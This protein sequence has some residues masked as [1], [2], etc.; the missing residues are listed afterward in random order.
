[1]TETPGLICEAP[2][3]EVL[4][5]QCL[6]AAANSETGYVP[7]RTLSALNGIG[8]ALLAARDQ[9]AAAGAAPA[10][11][12]RTLR[13]WL[14]RRQP[15]QDS[16]DDGAESCG[17]CLTARSALRSIGTPEEITA[18]IKCPACRNLPAASPDSMPDEDVLG[19]L[20]RLWLSCGW[21]RLE[22]QRADE[23]G[24]AGYCVGI[25]GDQIETAG[26]LADPAGYP[27]IGELAGLLAE[28]GW[29]RLQVTG[30]ILPYG[31]CARGDGS[32]VSVSEVLTGA[33]FDPRTVAVPRYAAPQVAAVPVTGVI[34]PEP[35]GDR[36]VGHYQ[37]VLLNTRT[38]ELRFHENTAHREPWNPDWTCSGDVPPETRD[39]W[40]PG[41]AFMPG[42][43]QD[44]WEPVPELLSWTVDSGVKEFPYLDADGANAL[45]DEIAPFA[46]GLLDGLYQTGE[47]LD[48]SA[49]SVNIGRDIC[50]LCSRKRQTAGVSPG[51]ADYSEIVRRFPY[52]F[53]PELLALP[54]GRLAGECESISRFLGCNE[55]WNPEVHEV[56]AIARYPGDGYPELH[57]YG[58][59]SWYRAAAGLRG[60]RS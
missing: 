48:W 12:K 8:Y 28:S 29:Q 11:G 18:G 3:S 53:R 54:A 47:D 22:I 50:G 33:P 17:D 45:L 49:G 25:T 7:E 37:Q 19:R 57:V 16:P 31:W 42:G 23:D 15:R 36:I 4:A 6:R 43:G 20:N 51:N 52:L 30:D 32:I 58:V 14:G 46:Q 44:Q 26:A 10:K 1:M 24:Y 59:R 9:L 5:L 40:Y 41:K 39:R 34:S 27:H 60:A 13:D 56:F 35:V 38:G 21:R 55:H 2:D